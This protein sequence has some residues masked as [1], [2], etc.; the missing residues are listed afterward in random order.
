MQNNKPSWIEHAKTC[1]RIANA[2]RAG[3]ASVKSHQHYTAR[4]HKAIKAAV[5]AEFGLP[6]DGPGAGC[7]HFGGNDIRL[8]GFSGLSYDS[9]V[10]FCWNWPGSWS[11][12]EDRAKHWSAPILAECDRV[13]MSDYLER[14]AAEAAIMPRL[15]EIEHS[16]VSAIAAARAEAAALIATVPLPATAKCRG[17]V[18]FEGRLTSPNDE[19]LKIIRGD[20]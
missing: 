4:V 7:F 9:P 15:L 18:H 20:A 5:R 8:W 13:D 14:N 17:A 6:E 10:F 2:V 16:L 12:A 3:V 19:A 1:V 11:S